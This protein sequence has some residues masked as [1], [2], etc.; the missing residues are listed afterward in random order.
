MKQVIFLNGVKTPN[1][2]L[3]LFNNS[4]VTKTQY[5]YRMPGYSFAYIVD[6]EVWRDGKLIAK[7]DEWEFKSRDVVKSNEEDQ[8]NLF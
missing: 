2:P 5:R 3:Y 6:G 7:K 8:T 4:I 1:E